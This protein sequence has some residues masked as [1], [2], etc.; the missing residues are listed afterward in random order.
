MAEAELY[1]ELLI[2]DTLIPDIFI[3]RYMPQ[4][5]KDAVSLYLWTRMAYK[6]GSF[7]LKDALAYSAIPEADINTALAELVTCGIL[8]RSSKDRFD[9]VDLKKLEVDEYLQAKTDHDGVPVMKSEE[10]ERNVLATSIQKTFYQGHMA[11]TFYRLIDKCLYEYHFDNQVVYAL[12]EEGKELRVHYIVPK[13]YELA[14]KW[15]EKGYVTT[16][17]LTDYYELRGRRT[18]IAKVTGRLLRK[19]LTELDYERFNRWAEVYGADAELVEYAIRVNE[20]RDSIRTVDVENKLK[21]WFDAGGMTIDKAAVYEAERHKENKVKASRG[22]GRTNVRRSGKEAG[23]TVGETK[24]AEPSEEESSVPIHDSILDM[25][26]G[27]DDE[28]DN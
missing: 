17:A 12:F 10:K 5:G 1:S 19:H 18:D 20:W 25:F 6:G 2:S 16:A 24:S 28:D 4:L 14:K 13:M 23:I 9:P 21:E 11:Y 22:K 27:D 15:Y 3:A 8:V 26:S 7:T